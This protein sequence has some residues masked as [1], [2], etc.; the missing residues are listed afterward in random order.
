VIALLFIL[1]TS[2]YATA[3]GFRPLSEAE[4]VSSDLSPQMGPVGLRGS[5]NFCHI[6][7]AADLINVN[8]GLTGERRVSRLDIASNMSVI[9]PKDFLRE[10]PAESLS[11]QA[12]RARLRN[13]AEFLQFRLAD[14]PKDKW[15][16]FPDM[17]IMALNRRDG[18]CSEKELPSQ[19]SVMHGG[20]SDYIYER[21]AAVERR[22][23]DTFTQWH[24]LTVCSTRSSLGNLA[25]FT[26]N[27]NRLGAREADT[28]LRAPC[29]NKIHL[30]PMLAHAVD[31]NETE[32]SRRMM[33]LLAQGIPAGVAY[34]H[35]VNGGA[36]SRQANHASTVAGAKWNA[37]T[38]QCEFKIRDSDGTSCTGVAKAWR[39]SGGEF[40]IPDKTF[41]AMA[42]QLFYIDSQKTQVSELK[43]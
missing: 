14:Y 13:Q 15:G 37:K 11:R 33:A 39:C 40:W 3:D 21:F 22:N 23:D 10:A 30:K 6:F 31:L 28:K 38:H 7:V 1:L 26:L 41:S 20:T 24:K 12:E 34:D 8:Q 2:G 43:D 5:S 35:S 16:G 25:E 19:A 18:V 32:G 9:D 4:C 36:V 42:T 17:D 27:F 29:K